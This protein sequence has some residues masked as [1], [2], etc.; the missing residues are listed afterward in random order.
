MI[1]VF[2]DGSYGTTGLRI[3]ERLIKRDDIDLLQINEKNKKNLDAR[4]ELIHQSDITILCLPDKESKEIVE[5]ID[6]SVRIIDT[7]SWH[8]TQDSFVYG[9][10]EIGFREKISTAKKVS[11]PGCHATGIICLSNIIAK[12]LKDN[13]HELSGVLGLMTK[14]QFTSITGYSGGGKKMIEEYEDKQ[15][16]F[17]APRIYNLE[18][19]HKHNKE[20]I[21]YSK[22]DD[23]FAFFPFVSN[24]YSG[25]LVSTNLNM[26]HTCILDS[27]KEMFQDEKLVKVKEGKDEILSSDKMSGKDDMVIHIF[28][29]NGGAVMVA[30]YDNLGKGASGAAIQCLNIMADLDET[31]GLIYD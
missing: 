10:P 17:S 31:E 11:V 15:N 22:L 1:K 26:E 13:G 28:D 12:A 8:R 18:Q 27:A 16:N 30:L 23:H 20:I 14:L 25:M 5:K 9:L 29:A 2:I 7:S 21:K 3:K 19:T 6:D 24:Y 4:L